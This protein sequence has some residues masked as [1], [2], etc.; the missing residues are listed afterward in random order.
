MI[1]T[2]LVVCGVATGFMGLL[3]MFLSGSQKQAFADCIVKC[4]DRLH[5]AHRFSLYGWLFQPGFRVW[6]VAAPTTVILGA[7]VLILLSGGGRV[8]S[9]RGLGLAVAI[10]A[11]ILTGGPIGMLMLRHILSRPSKTGILWA[12]LYLLL[13]VGAAAAI[14]PIVMSEFMTAR[15][16]AFVN[17]RPPNVLRMGLSL[18]AFYSLVVILLY[19]LVAALPVVIVGVAQIM[20]AVSEFTVRKIAESPKGVIM[21]M[22]GLLTSV[23]GIL[24]AF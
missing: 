14:L 16:G 19:W 23:G 13:I 2:F 7:A 8:L 21:G 11:A 17:P 18:W 9:A 3:D 1:A 12:A 5:E 4:W 22:S 24:R 10:F 6:F 20:L 15:I